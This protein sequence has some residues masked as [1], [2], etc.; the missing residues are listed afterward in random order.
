MK[1]LFTVAVI[2]LIGILFTTA[3]SKKKNPTPA[4]TPTI[5]TIQT[6]VTVVKQKHR[7]A[8]IKPAHTMI[9]TPTA[10]PTPV[11]AIT[12]VPA[13]TIAVLPKNELIIP[14]SD[15]IYTDFSNMANDGL[16]KSEDSKY[17]KLN[18]ITNKEAAVYISEAVKNSSRAATPGTAQAVSRQAGAEYSD[19][20]TAY[21]GRF[22]NEL[23]ELPDTEKYINQPETDKFSESV[24][25]LLA[26]IGDIEN[27]FKNTVFSDQPPL[28]ITGNLTSRWTDM[29]SSGASN[30]RI[31]ALSTILGMTIDSTPM[32][33][34]E[35]S[36]G[37]NVGEGGTSDPRANG[38]YNTSTVS[39]TLYNWKITAGMFWDNVS[40]FTVS[41]GI[42]LRPIIFDRDIYAG[43]EKTKDHF[44]NLIHNYSIH[45]D[46]RW[47]MH[48]WMGADVLN[49]NFFGL[50]QLKLMA[51]KV[52]YNQNFLYEY[53]GQLTR[54]QNL[55]G[56]YD[57]DW[58]LNFYN[59]SNEKSEIY[60][61][62]PSGQPTDSTIANT[63]AGASVKTNVIKLMKTN[64]E[65]AI[66]NNY[67]KCANDPDFYDNWNAVPVKPFTQT[68]S[69]LFIDAF[70]A[71]PV[72]NM[73]LELRYTR[74]DS[75]YFSA[76]SGVNNTTYEE[77][78]HTTN[79]VDIKNITS[80]QDPTT[81][82]N[83]ENK[84]EATVKVNIPNGMFMLNYGVSS[85]L[86][87]TGN[88]FFSTHFLNGDVRDG[89]VYFN[90]LGSNYGW[91]GS[92]IYQPFLNYN[93]NR[94]G[95]APT[96]DNTLLTNQIIHFNKGGLATAIWESNTEYMVSSAVTG[97]TDKFYNNLTLDFRY[98]LNKL[99]KYNRDVLLMVYSELTTLNNDASLMVDYNPNRLLC[100]NITS[101]CLAY[102]IIN[103]VNLIGFYAVERWASNNVI[104]YGIDYL[105]TAYGT[106]F[107][108]D[109][110]SRA[111]LYLRLKEFTHK[112]SEVPANNFNGWEVYAEV[113]DYF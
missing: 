11:I 30:M 59:Q 14:Q 3:C 110:G 80:A 33:N 99:I 107:D 20:L 51:G 88:M 16:I 64:V 102:N 113:K 70:P 48:P 95:I 66:A 97:N 63:V 46:D 18:A 67:G 17:F 111:S 69:A 101:G 82:S 57:T 12:P 7:K 87:D 104:P 61:G 19:T 41:S 24:E 81:M 6:P 52:T 84:I 94:Y 83:N 1:K 43:E 47:S 27:D 36:L 40:L 50:G 22:A 38:N 77:I 58:S 42:T 85:Q 10:P 15:R 28:K 109:F 5:I 65:F 103:S 106:G 56:L 23:S 26:E 86:K 35:L 100:Q 75:D 71:L 62:A 31:S 73:E 44:E 53:A 37:Y 54:R 39:L 98:E 92:N 112:D 89:A 8:R 9:E 93:K 13:A 79:Q 96:A 68:G 21:A 25:A 90:F 74:I 29:E 108:Y 105:D 49:S 32:D 45:L 60:A 4:T 72:K 91:L 34:V 55:P 76:G 2:I 78:N